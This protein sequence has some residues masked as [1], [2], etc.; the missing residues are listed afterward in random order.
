MFLVQFNLM[1]QYCTSTI[2]NNEL[3][4]LYTK[5]YQLNSNGNMIIFTPNSPSIFSTYDK[6]IQAQTDVSNEYLNNHS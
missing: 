1:I 5:T 3:F 2:I 4:Y 6:G